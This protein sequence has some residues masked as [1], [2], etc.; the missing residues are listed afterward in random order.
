MTS[1]RP[2]AGAAPLHRISGGDFWRKPFN[3]LN[4]LSDSVFLLVFKSSPSAVR[5]L[6]ETSAG[7]PAYRTPLVLTLSRCLLKFNKRMPAW[8]IC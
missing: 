4:F 6:P 5:V 7:R 8:P 3:P 2:A 1:G